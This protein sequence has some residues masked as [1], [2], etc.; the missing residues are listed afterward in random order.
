VAQKRNLRRVHL[1][2]GASD[3]MGR[4]IDGMFSVFIDEDDLVEMMARASTNKT[5]R[6][7]SGPLVVEYQKATSAEA[8]FL[9]KGEAFG[10]LMPAFERARGLEKV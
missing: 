1:Q 7:T 8:D 6:A 4:P 5:R 10:K 9:I 2:S 3:R